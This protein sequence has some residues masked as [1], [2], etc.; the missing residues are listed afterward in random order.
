[1]AISSEWIAPD[2]AQ[3]DVWKY[4][5]LP[6]GERDR[7]EKSV[8]FAFGSFDGVDASKILNETN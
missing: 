5:I 7:C 2:V 6:S 4:S 1:M 8:R 3:A